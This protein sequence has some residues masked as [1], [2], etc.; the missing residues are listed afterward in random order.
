VSVGG[1]PDAPI[2]ESV[3]DYPRPP[4]LEPFDGIVEVELG[5]ELVVRTGGAWRV[6]ETSHPPSYYLPPQDFV[7]GALTPAGGSSYCEWKG[8]A[9]YY[10]IRGGGV[11]AR[12]A[13]WAYPD[14]T[15]AFHPIR[16]YVAL[17][18]GRMDVCRVDGE[19]VTPQ[20]GGFYGGWITSNLEGPF[21][22]GPG[23]AGW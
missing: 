9:T 16:G 3:W 14:P 21:K 23:T 8:L 1:D 2:L 6:L 11:T 15:P 4:A 5:G 22:G 17:Y 7:E 10:D 18:A 19:S 12:R 20:P 13:G